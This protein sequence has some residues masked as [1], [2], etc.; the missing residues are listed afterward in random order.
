MSQQPFAQGDTVKHLKTGGI[1]EILTFGRD[2]DTLEDVVTYRCKNSRFKDE[3]EFTW[4]RKRAEFEDGR[5][6]KVEISPIPL[7]A[8]PFCKSP[9]ILYTVGDV[10]HPMWIAACSNDKKSVKTGGCMVHPS[11]PPR[12]VEG[13]AEG[14]WNRRSAP[15]LT[16]D[17]I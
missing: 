16:P 8:C 4:T 12:F 17:A 5:F 1:Y 7:A 9:G 3:R 15:T 2:V 10:S 13:E 6:E 11:T 14:D